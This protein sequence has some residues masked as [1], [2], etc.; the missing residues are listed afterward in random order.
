[1]HHA[2]FVVSLAVV[3]G[4]FAL[5]EIQIEGPNGWA[6]SLPTWR[7]E[8]RWTR[9]FYSA[10]PITGYH[11][12][13][14]L[15]ALAVVHLPFGLGLTP[16]TWRAEARILSFFILFWVLEDFLWFVFNPAFGIKR[17]RPQHIW[18]H[19]PTWWWIMPRDYWI[20]APLAAGL[21][22]ISCR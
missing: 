5:V 13:T 17:F 21:Y 12:Y 1:M 2:I 9:R 18:W 6:A 7:I 11:L 10:K 20:F 22:I 3:A 4:L 19:A 14:Q 15:F 16:V 8:N